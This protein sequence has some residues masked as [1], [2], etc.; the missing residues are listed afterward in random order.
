MNAF[1]YLFVCVSMVFLHLCVVAQAW[2]YTE[3]DIGCPALEPQ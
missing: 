2:A 1:V 3:K